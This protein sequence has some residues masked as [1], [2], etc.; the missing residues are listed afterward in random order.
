MDYH[1]FPQNRRLSLGLSDFKRALAGKIQVLFLS[2]D[3]E[4]FCLDVKT[5]FAKFAAFHFEIVRR[6]V[7]AGW[8]TLYLFTVMC[9]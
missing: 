7:G 5:H 3:V 4:E 6:L 9:V 1:A 2:E 8:V